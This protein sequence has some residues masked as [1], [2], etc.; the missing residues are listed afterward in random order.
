MELT[1]KEKVSNPECIIGVVGSIPKYEQWGSN[2]IKV[3][4]RIW[5]NLK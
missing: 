1:K 2:N 5:I 4:G 3:D